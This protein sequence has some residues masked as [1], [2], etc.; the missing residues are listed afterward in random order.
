MGLHRMDTLVVS[1]L[2]VPA[3]N[4]SLARTS[5]LCNEETHAVPPI[6]MDVDTKYSLAALASSSSGS[7]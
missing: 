1:D 6:N 7:R 2:P 5:A 3:G 4:A